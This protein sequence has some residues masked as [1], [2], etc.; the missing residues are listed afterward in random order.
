MSQILRK[1][2]TWYTHDLGHLE[3]VENGVPY[4]FMADTVLS[5]VFG[6]CERRGPRGSGDEVPQKLTLF[7]TE[8]LNF[9]VLEE[10]N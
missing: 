4:F 7:V 2:A 9:D 1:N 5:G 6:M 8:C 10:K 3:Q